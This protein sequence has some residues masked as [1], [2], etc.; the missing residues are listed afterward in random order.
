LVY[1]KP[2]LKNPKLTPL[3]NN[4]KSGLK[5]SDNAFSVLNK[6]LVRNLKLDDLI[7]TDVPLIE[8]I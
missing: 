8:R 2:R 7:Q 1:P 5:E 3:F 4:S 6:P